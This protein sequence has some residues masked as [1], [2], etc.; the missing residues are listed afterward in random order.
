[1]T[2]SDGNQIYKNHAYSVVRSDEEY[3]YVINPWDSGKE[4]RLTHE[5]FKKAYQAVLTAHTLV[6]EQA[7]S[8]MTS[9]SRRFP[10]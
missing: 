7:K 3:V 6:K 5:E 4:I 1:L 2:T 9:L 10:P 8:G